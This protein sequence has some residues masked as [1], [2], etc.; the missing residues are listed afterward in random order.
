MKTKMKI[1]DTKISKANK[2]QLVKIIN[3]LTF[4]LPCFIILNGCKQDASTTA[5]HTANHPWKL[6]CIGD[7]ITAG[8][9]L[10]PDFAYPAL[11]EKDYLKEGSTDVKVVNAGI[12]GETIQGID[13]RIEWMLQQR[14]NAILLSLGSKELTKESFSFWE[15]CFKKI[16]LTNPEATI[17]VG[18][19]SQTQTITDIKSYFS[20]LIIDYD[21]ELI[22]LQLLE[23]NATWW[24]TDMLYPS[25]EGQRVLADILFK[26]LKNK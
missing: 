15:N 9:G 26:Y 10:D 16:R 1:N 2:Q 3:I 6:I 17:L 8:V 7:G 11:L 24:Q 14:F 23:N 18:I 22:D 13:Q 5:T 20:P 12:K 4:I 21:V 19:V 25:K